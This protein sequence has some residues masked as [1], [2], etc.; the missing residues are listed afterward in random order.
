M[1]PPEDLTSFSRE[2][3]LALVAEQ[4]RQITALTTTLEALQAEIARLT[5]NAKGQAAPFSKG[6]RV[7]EP[8]R[9]GRKPGSGLFRYREAPRPEEITNPPV[10]VK[11]M[12]EACPACGGPLEEERGDLVYT[13]ELPELP[14]PTITQYRVWVCRCTVC[15]KRVRGAHPNVA[16]D[17][18]GATAHRLGPRLMAVAHALH[19]GAGLPVRKVPTVLQAL[20]GVRLTQSAVTQDALRRA[21]GAVGTAYEQL[22]AA[23]PAAPVVHTDDTG[24]RIGGDPAYLM[25]FETATATVYQIRP[26]H[27]HQEVQEVIP[28]D[29]DGVMVTDRGRS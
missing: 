11:V 22:R 3:L 23:V 4:Q 1:I 12:L 19:Y 15:G 29:Y 7:V 21:A 10:D 25:A 16:P 8:K 28:T 18:A 2:D 5:R 17:Q 26:R 27:R 24:W 6:T 13:T 14:R 20:T 9:P